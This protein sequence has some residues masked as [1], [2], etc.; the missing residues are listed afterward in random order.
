MAA[1]ASECPYRVTCRLSPERDDHGPVVDTQGRS[2]PTAPMWGRTAFYRANRDCHVFG[3]RHG[4]VIKTAGV[5]EVL[6]QPL[7]PLEDRIEVAFLYASAA[8]GRFQAADSRATGVRRRGATSRAASSRTIQ[9][10]LARVGHAQGG[11]RAP[12]T[13]RR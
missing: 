6:L 9:K 1:S 13:W 5:A 3:E 11:T 4:P 2:L 12:A 10:R 7:L 8:E